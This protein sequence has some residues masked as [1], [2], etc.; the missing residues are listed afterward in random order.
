MAKQRKHRNSRASDFF[1]YA[2]GKT[3]GKDR[4][5]FERRLQKD[6]FEAEAAEGLGM[7]SREEMEED[8]QEVS[9][10]ILR[11]SRRRRRIA[12]YSA[13]AAVASLMIVAT[14]F[15]N[16]G[17]GSMERYRTA[18]EFEE[19]AQE[20]PS[21]PAMEKDESKQPGITD[22][23]AG[24]EKEILPGKDRSLEK[25]TG[26]EGVPKGDEVTGTEVP[27]YVAPGTEAREDVAPGNEAPGVEKNIRER[28][29]RREKKADA[30]QIQEDVVPKEALPKDAVAK[31]I[32]EKEIVEKEAG[33]QGVIAQ[34]VAA[35]EALAQEELI[36]AETSEK[37]PMQPPAA[38]EK[39]TFRVTA[40]EAADEMANAPAVEAAPAAA[41]EITEEKTEEIAPDAAQ[42]VT[43]IEVAATAKEEPM[44]ALQG[45][46]QGV[47][48]SQNMQGQ[49]SGIVYSADDLQPLPGVSLS[50]KGSNEGTVSDI[51]GSF[52]LTTMD[53]AGG[54]LVARSIGMQTEEIPLDASQ[55]MEIAMVPDAVQLDEVVVVG[56]APAKRA[57]TT[58]SV[59]K[60]ETDPAAASE[61]ITASPVDGIVAFKQYMDTTLI[62][63]T[64]PAPA[65]KEVV[66]LKFSITP[67]GQ[68]VNFR[69]IRSPGPPFTQ[70]AI[71]VLS[72]G[73][74]WRPTTN[75]GTYVEDDVRLRIVF[76]PAQQ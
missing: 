21:G 39:A 1:D 57:L 25:A 66:V 31:E 65:E 59:S 54:T 13:A 2:G 64:V 44:Q 55:P 22:M 32:V 16:I 18:P 56:H 72:Q 17:D 33:A 29:A 60:V 61:Y 12:W 68:P 11:R 51:N 58:V 24:P 62:Y 20:Q 27:E 40:D 37:K 63:P 14:I 7:V 43:A 74:D 48:L 36:E 9:L 38:K 15:F 69:V 52:R 46:V 42:D 67:N 75:N 76:R 53:H 4:N 30:E 70:E 26:N 73:P 34:E 71:R 49:V 35:Q 10:K 50:I 6:P 19:A 28:T 45:Q 8:L 23:E 41:L 5:A 47:A 3:R